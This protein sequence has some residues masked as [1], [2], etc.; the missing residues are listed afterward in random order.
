MEVVSVD[1]WFLS[2]NKLPKVHLYLIDGNKH[3]TRHCLANLH[4][5]ISSKFIRYG[6]A[7]FSLTAVKGFQ[8]NRIQ[9]DFLFSRFSSLF[10]VLSFVYFFVSYAPFFPY[11]GVIKHLSI[12]NLL[13]VNPSIIFQANLLLNLEQLSCKLSLSYWIYTD[14]F[15]FHPLL[16]C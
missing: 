12:L 14:I 10:G 15:L 8:A 1:F 16:Y 3:R 7:H 6:Y 11:P 2:P 5:I 4:Q 9:T 13:T